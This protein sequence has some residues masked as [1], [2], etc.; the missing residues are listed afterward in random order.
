MGDMVTSECKKL[1]KKVLHCSKKNTEGGYGRLPLADVYT[2]HGIL[3]RMHEFKKA[4]S[5]TFIHKFI[6]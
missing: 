4:N 3:S 6:T 2:C 1:T 5:K